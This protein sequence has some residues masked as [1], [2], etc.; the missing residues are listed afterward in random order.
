M[1]KHRRV[2]MFNADARFPPMLRG[3]TLPASWRDLLEV[4]RPE[5]ALCCSSTFAVFA[6]L[7]TGLVAQAMR[8]TVVGMLAA[9]GMAAIV[10]FHTCCRFFWCIAGH[11]SARARLG[12]GDRVPAALRGRGDRGG[13]RR[14]PVPPLGTQGVRCVL[15][16]RRFRAGPARARPGQPMGDRRHGRRVGV[17]RASGV[18]PVLFRLWA[19]KGTASPV[20][21]QRN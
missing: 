10:S 21:L 1:T 9:T 5:Q 19:G 8:R 7:A 3:L 12:A 16:A 4:F 17:L 13:R 14:H 18:L 2:W 20:R 15:D 11:R 6:L